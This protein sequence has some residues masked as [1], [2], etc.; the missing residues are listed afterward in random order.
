MS[1][2]PTEEPECTA[3]DEERA[4]DLVIEGRPRDLAGMPV[5]RVLP[6]PRRR[7]VGPFI[8]LDHMGPVDFEPG[9]GLDVPPHPHVNLATVTYLFEGEILHRD[10]LGTELAISP[11]DVN[12]MTAGRGIVHSERTSPARRASAHRL[13]GVQL[14][15]ALPEEHEESAPRFTHH[16]ADVFEEIVM[17][18]AKAR[19]LAGEAFGVTSPIE[20]CSPLFYVDVELRA[21]GRVRVPDDH[22]ERAAYVAKGSVTS[23]GERFGVGSLVVF[24]ETRRAELRADGDARVMLLGGALLGERHMYWNFV[25]SRRERLEQAKDDWRA[26]RFPEVPGDEGGRAPMP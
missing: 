18:G 16:S 9:R 11:G 23:G 14:W 1:W 17:E 3:L 26:G 15:V 8:F 12:W 22:P 20:V 25:S 19:V 21:G 4:I 7:M 10:S 2:L 5:I 24:A 13:D 6:S